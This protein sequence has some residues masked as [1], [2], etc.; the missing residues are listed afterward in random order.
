MHY[1][2]K[3]NYETIMYDKRKELNGYLSSTMKFFG[4]N[5]L[6]DELMKNPTINYYFHIVSFVYYYFFKPYLTFFIAL[7]FLYMFFY[8]IKTKKIILVLFISI[9]SILVYGMDKA[10]PIRMMS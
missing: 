4:L 10:T 1:V 9:I 7:L 8:L 6:M 2:P 3:N 5:E